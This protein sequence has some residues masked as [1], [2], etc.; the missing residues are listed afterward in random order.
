MDL[1]DTGVLLEDEFQH[2]T[3]S[4]DRYGRT[5]KLLEVVSRKSGE[6]F[7]RFCDAMSVYHQKHVV[8]LLE[9]GRS[10]VIIT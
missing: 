10:S 2:I 5:Q 4:E 7:Q 1:L 9:N 3:S 6:A 8:A